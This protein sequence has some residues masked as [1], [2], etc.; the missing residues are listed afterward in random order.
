[1]IPDR[2]SLSAFLDW[3]RNG[4]HEFE[5]SDAQ[6]IDAY[7]VIEG[8]LETAGGSIPPISSWRTLLAPVLCSSQTQQQQFYDVFV[9][10]FGES[11][12]RIEDTGKTRE[13][14]RFLGWLLSVQINRDAWLYASV[15]VLLIAL[16]GWF[17][18][19]YLSTK[20]RTTQTLEP[21][22]VIYAK[23]EHVLSD[24]VAVIPETPWGAAAAQASAQFAGSFYAQSKTGEI[25]LP[26]KTGTDYV[27]VTAPHFK[28]ALIELPKE[29]RLVILRPQEPIKLA[30]LF[31]SWVDRHQRHLHVG[32][33]SIP[34]LLVLIWLMS[35][36]RRALELRRWA[37]AI[38][39]RMRRIGSPRKPESVFKASDMRR[40]S[41]ALRRRR[42]EDSTE[43][44][45]E[46][47]A[48]ETCRG[49]GFFSPVYEQRSAEPDYLFLGERKNLRD[50]QSRFQDELL[51]RLRDFD[52]SVQRYYF[53]SDPL[54]CSDLKGRVF[55]LNEISALHSSHELWIALESTECVE[56]V[57]GQP[58][59][60]FGLIAAWREN[61]LL[62]FSKQATTLAVRTTTP[63]RPGLE[64]LAGVSS[65]PD[66]EPLPSLLRT[67]PERWVRPII[68]AGANL[69][70]LNVQLRL[71]L[72][73]DGFL[74]LQ[75]CAVYPALAWNITLTLAVELVAAGTREEVLSKIVALPWFRHGTMPDWLRAK[76]LAQLG[77]DEPRVRSALRKYLDQHV[78]HAAE[79]HE[80]L[81]IVPGKLLRSSKKPALNDYIYLSFVSGKRLDRLSAEAPSRWRRFLRD[82]VWLRIALAT[83]CV[84]LAWPVTEWAIHGLS[85]WLVAR[86][87]REVSVELPTNPFAREVYLVALGL[88]PP[89]EPFK[90]RVLNDAMVD[91]RI[92]SMLLGGENPIPSASALEKISERAPTG[93][94]RPGMLAQLGSSFHVVRAE[95][96]GM[97][98]LFG[99]DHPTTLAEVQQVFDLSNIAM[100]A[101]A[102]PVSPVSEP[103]KITVKVSSPHSDQ[104]DAEPIHR[105]SP[106]QQPAE[107]SEVQ[108]A[109]EKRL[110]ST[111]EAFAEGVAEFRFGMSPAAVSNLFRDPLPDSFYDNLPVAGEYR[112]ADVR[113]FWLRLSVIKDA[114]R[115]GGYMSIMGP[116]QACMQGGSQSYVT[117]L[118]EKGRLFRVSSRFFF[119]CPDR[120]E[121]IL[122]LFRGLGIQEQ[123]PTTAHR[124]TLDFGLTKLTWTLGAD[125]SWLD[126]WENNSPMPVDSYDP[127]VAGDQPARPVKK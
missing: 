68:P 105:P 26:R 121:R 64:H 4:A 126:V 60:W 118:F 55:A 53:Q 106:R 12:P 90:R 2:Q 62:S 116:L 65:L 66:L 32:T 104:S 85:K 75:A 79:R 103:A 17:L 71:F 102:K 34:I 47:T 46:G 50:Q 41:V 86:T 15:A 21:G 112:T 61:A 30:S 92:A 3:L 13:P 20:A 36:W 63:T 122:E 54:V 74:L 97:L 51:Q 16:S 25:W 19:G 39:P 107:T 44:D 113:Y 42:Q 70:R 80:A 114:K 45:L 29:S 93:S 110:E 111:R 40:L 127:N 49:G 89:A 119:D 69:D 96:N 124:L 125:D 82:S 72:G 22:R 67:A 6:F 99:V 123:L 78:S 24:Q 109:D 76:L 37:A 43:L 14:R 31:A 73:P 95:R 59:P 77:A 9:T 101:A 1:M 23:W 11:S 56:P 33:M 84:G 91:C 52:V 117:F 5:A 48:E 18:R 88:E 35:L 38:E 120:D 94:V 108:P 27:L 7:A 98:L 28:P 100:L 10:W 115:V 8:V 81:E 87:Q 57:S 83:A 58:K